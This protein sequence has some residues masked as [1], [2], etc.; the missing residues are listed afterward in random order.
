MRLH[1]PGAVGPLLLLSPTKGR[2]GKAGYREGHHTFTDQT[3]LFVFARPFSFFFHLGTTLWG[4]LLLLFSSPFRS[5]GLFLFL[6]T[7]A[8]LK[9]LSYAIHC[10]MAN[11]VAILKP[12][13]SL[14]ARSGAGEKG[15]REERDLAQFNFPQFP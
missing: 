7:S 2:R 4:G 8:M 5:S 9:A 3:A 15:K 10:K 14:C 11:I 6:S 13:C 12:D 1:L